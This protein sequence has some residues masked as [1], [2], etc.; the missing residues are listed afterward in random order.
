MAIISIV[1]A[2]SENNVIGK[3]NQLLWHLPDDLKFFK[4]QTLNKVIVMGRKT[5]ESIGNK[6][7]PKRTNVV[8]SRNAGLEVPDNVILLNSVEEAIQKYQ[9]EEEICIVGGEQIYRL[10]LPLVNEIYITRV[11]ISLDGDTYFPEISEDEFELVSEDYHNQDE[12]HAI[13]FTFQKW[14]RKNG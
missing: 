13:S 8:I 14:K 7:L 12:K 11:H 4:S 2:A 10:A 6:A 1:V 3:D 9:H 5:F